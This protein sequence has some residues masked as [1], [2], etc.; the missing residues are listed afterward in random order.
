MYKLYYSKTWYNLENIE[1]K[2]VGEVLVPD[3]VYDQTNYYTHLQEQALL[4]ETAQFEEMEENITEH[5]FTKIKND[6]LAPIYAELVSIIKRI[7]HNQETAYLEEYNHLKEL[8]LSK[9]VSITDKQ[10]VWLG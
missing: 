8:I 9:D 2:M 4:Y 3:F 1:E 5:K 6:L 7:T 10:Y